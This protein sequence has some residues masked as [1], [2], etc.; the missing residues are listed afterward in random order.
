MAYNQLIN[1]Y[2]LT[3]RGMDLP[4]MDTSFSNIYKISTVKE[5]NAE[6]LTYSQ[7]QFTQNV[8]FSGENLLKLQ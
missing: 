6:I 2:V 7:I 5:T 3:A 4:C 8:K 1:V